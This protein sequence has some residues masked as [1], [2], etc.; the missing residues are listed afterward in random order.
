VRIV[1][2]NW[3]V[4]IHD[5]HVV[6]IGDAMP[7]KYPHDCLDR[8][9]IAPCHRHENHAGEG[10]EEDVGRRRGR[11]GSAFENGLVSDRT[12]VDKYVCILWATSLQV[13]LI[14]L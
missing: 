13:K 12:R 1:N 4:D 5:T 10:G 2:I 7:I 3:E 6:L 8:V 9:P 11:A 14:K